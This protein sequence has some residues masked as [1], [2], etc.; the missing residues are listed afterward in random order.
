M[1]GRLRGKV[2]LITG[3]DSGIGRATAVEFAKEGADVVV[4]YLHDAEGAEE[5]R[6]RV[7]AAGG[8]SVAV[9]ADVSDEAQVA[10]IFDRAVAEF[11]RVDILVNN[12][13]LD[14]SG[15][16]VAELSTDV[17]DRAIRTNLY[18]YFFCARRFIQLRR[19]A[20]GG[21]KI[22]NVTSV[23]EEIPRAG[24]ADYDCSKGAIRN[25]TERSPSS[26][27]RTTS[28]STTSHPGWCLPRST[29]RRSTTRKPARSRRAAFH[30]SERP[31]HPRSG[32]WPCSL[33]PRT[34]TT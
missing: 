23:H 19:S 16:Q 13:G 21:G 30:G 22:I 12:A 5:T 32:V 33:P 4:N 27:P 20:G 24:A 8:R 10:S 26:W 18:G 14:A 1:A 15:T 31:T 17:W 3:S 28:T 9:Q 29:K 6:R 34:R 25:L 11:G 2:A 7:E